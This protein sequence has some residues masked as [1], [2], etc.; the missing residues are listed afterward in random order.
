MLEYLGFCPSLARADLA[1][2]AEGSLDGQSPYGKV[3]CEVSRRA[4]ARAS[5]PSRWPGPSAGSRKHSAHGISAFASIV[6]PA[7]LA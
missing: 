1:T 7:L 4:E 6:K 3:P 2:T 5:P